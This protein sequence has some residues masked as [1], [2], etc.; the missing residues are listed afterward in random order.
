[1]EVSWGT[2]AGQFSPGEGVGGSGGSEGVSGDE[3]WKCISPIPL[4]PNSS[5]WS[6]AHCTQGPDK[7]GVT[8]E[9]Q[10]IHLS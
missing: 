10:E 5:S 6:R 1:M 4:S 7:H 2:S 3:E 9:T 8:A